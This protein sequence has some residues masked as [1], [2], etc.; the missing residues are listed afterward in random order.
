M[1]IKKLQTLYKKAKKEQD[2][3]LQSVMLRA[4]DHY[5]TAEALSAE[6]VAVE[7]LVGENAIIEFVGSRAYADEAATIYSKFVEGTLNDK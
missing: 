6:T 2:T 4:L 1:D 3:H 7:S 5:V